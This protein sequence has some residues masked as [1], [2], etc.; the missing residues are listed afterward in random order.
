MADNAVPFATDDIGGV[1]HPR[2]KV[3]HGPDGEATDVSQASPLP[4]QAVIRSDALFIG[5][6]SVTP[7]FALISASSSSTITIQAAQASA[8]MRVLSYV[9]NAKATTSV[10]FNSSVTPLT[11]MMEFDKYGGAAAPYCHV[12]H[13][14]TTV[15]QPLTITTGAG[16]VAGHV[17]L[18]PVSV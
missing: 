9:L 1:F 14:Q 7:V 6:V 3:E 5:S 18:V 11:G 15:G 16:A 13:F 8:R 4:V 10:T 2:V 12:G 17:V